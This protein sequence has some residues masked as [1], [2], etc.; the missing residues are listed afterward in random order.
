MDVR[1]IGWSGVDW[2]NL[3]ENTDQWKALVNM[4]MNLRAGSS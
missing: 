4:V 1:E 2:I 3:A